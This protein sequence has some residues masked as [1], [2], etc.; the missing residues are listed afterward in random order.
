MTSL[1]GIFYAG[2]T[3]YVRD[4]FKASEKP[5]KPCFQTHLVHRSCRRER[6]RLR[7]KSGVPNQVC[8]VYKQAGSC[9]I[10]G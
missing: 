5:F 1:Y 6:I 8:V 3:D 7:R 2:G 10:T 4:L 9:C